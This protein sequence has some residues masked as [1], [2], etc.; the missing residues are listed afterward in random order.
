MLR[1]LSF[2]FIFL[3]LFTSGANAQS[4]PQLWQ[5][6]SLNGESQ[7]E[8]A[9]GTINIPEDLLKYV[10]RMRAASPNQLQSLEIFKLDSNALQALINR[11]TVAI[12]VAT[13]SSAS[14]FELVD[15]S[16]NN[17]GMQ[18]ISAAAFNKDRKESSLRLTGTEKAR[19][20]TLILKGQRWQVMVFGDYG[21]LIH[22][23]DV[24]RSTGGKDVV[25]PAKETAAEEHNI[26]SFDYP[27]QPDEETSSD[28]I[29]SYFA[30]VMYNQASIDLYGSEEAVLARIAEIQEVTND[31]YRDSNLELRMMIAAI[32]LIDVDPDNTTSFDEMK[33]DISLAPSPYDTLSKH[34][35]FGAFAKAEAVGA[36]FMMM[37]RP[38]T[39]GGV[40]GIATAG[41]ADG[42]AYK[43]LHMVSLNGLNCQDDIVAHEVG[44]NMGLAHSRRQNSYGGYSF[45]YALGY[46][47]DNEFTTVM[48]YPSEF[49]VNGSQTVYRYSSPELDCF[50]APCGIDRNDPVNGADARYALQQRTEDIVS[51][52][53]SRVFDDEIFALRTNGPV[54]VTGVDGCGVV[55][56]ECLATVPKG[57]EIKLEALDIHYNE[58]FV[59]WWFE[60]EE[61]TAT[62]CTL[63]ADSLIGAYAEFEVNEL[64]VTLAEAVDMQGF[65]VTGSFVPT[66][67]DS[68]RGDISVQSSRDAHGNYYGGLSVSVPGPGTFTFDAK[69]ILHNSEDA[70]L[71]AG[72][73]SIWNAPISIDG[74]NEWETYSFEIS[75]FDF[76]SGNKV[77][78]GFSRPYD[79]YSGDDT[80]FLDN[81]RFEPDPDYRLI[82]L[83]PHN[84]VI[85]RVSGMLNRDCTET[86]YIP[87]RPGNQIGIALSDESP[88]DIIGW[89]GICHG[90]EGSCEFSVEE[91]LTINI[92]GEVPNSAEGSLNDLLDNDSLSFTTYGESPK[93]FFQSDRYVGGSALTHY[94]PD[95]LTEDFNVLTSVVGSGTLSFSWEVNG[96][97][98]ETAAGLYIN[99][100]RVSGIN[101][102]AG[103]KSAS[104]EINAEH[105]GEVTEVRWSHAQ[106]RTFSNEMT[107]MT[108]DNVQW[109]GNAGPDY[110][111]RLKING[112]GLIRGSNGWYCDSP[113]CSFPRIGGAYRLVAEPLGRFE[114]VRWLGACSGSD[115]VCHVESTQQVKSVTAEFDIPKVSIETQ[116]VGNGRL[117]PSSSLVDLDSS[118][119]I[120]VIPAVG[121]KVSQVT[122]CDGDWSEGEL[123]YSLVAYENC[124]VRAEFEP[125]DY[126]VTFQLPEQL[127]RVG[128][129]ALQQSVAYGT[130]ADE[131]EVSAAWG[132]NFGGW[133]KSFH[134]IT[135]NTSIEGV[136]QR[137]DNKPRVNVAL[138]KGA[139]TPLKETQYIDVGETLRIPFD[140]TPTYEVVKQVKGDCP[141]GSFEDNL[142]I[143]GEIVESCTVKLLFTQRGRA[144][145]LLLIL[146]VESLKQESNQ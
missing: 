145:S 71:K 137:I 118:L 67:R 14:T 124:T 74:V 30:Y 41:G 141:A 68:S 94:N 15:V 85:L 31:V 79:L 36:D 108:L 131:P 126:T 113:T 100:Q 39:T 84:G 38:Y 10:E 55:Y 13:M 37:F 7:S 32:D 27:F 2:F 144:N 106:T 47:V 115:P 73:N 97:R 95:A 96:K 91:S 75:E 93:D 66:L 119:D 45:D 70:E 125:L 9:S 35:F 92:F 128:G 16:D 19:A 20:G 17:L 81:L 83:V 140:L 142:Y 122:G 3:L 44:H 134:S 112:D 46:G 117:S 5:S 64:D 57:S 48:A 76:Y 120:Q 143:T 42:S 132:W 8:Q 28:G 103:F 60:C 69:T 98:N 49:N 80:V 87:V 53:D 40:C 43:P 1:A 29:K 111:T 107:G 135:D 54:R 89:S 23:R 146:S 136:A 63:K 86:C 123:L 62:T 18:I 22:E 12:N 34:A 72:F 138:G 58:E 61:R 105:P 116:A 104:Y 90:N 121:H 56:T 82:K 50:G 52:R 51:I 65:E 99:E 6:V 21:V 102:T 133:S 127:E 130:A 26:F 78:I 25:H 139:T 109:T 129:G 33:R 77:V 88:V 101:D 110:V 114:F 4:E 11:Q 59:K 24:P